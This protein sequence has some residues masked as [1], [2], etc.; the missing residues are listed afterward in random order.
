MYRI[1][2]QPT[3]HAIRPG[4]I[5]ISF[6]IHSGFIVRAYFDLPTG[7]LPLQREVAG[8]T[9]KEDMEKDKRRNNRSAVY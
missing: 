8:G 1:L 6:G 5:R 4:F 7:H 9:G 3:T 2:T